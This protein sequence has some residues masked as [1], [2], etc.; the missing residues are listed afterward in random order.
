MHQRIMIT[1]ITTCVA[2][3]ALLICSIFPET[4]TFVLNVEIILLPAIYVVGNL[5]IE[6][7]LEREYRKKE[8][9]QITI[10]DS[11]YGKMKRLQEENM[12]LILENSRLKHEP[13]R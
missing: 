6:R 13:L 1:I 10:L 2:L 3:L 4:I 8:S 7:A 11:I 9:Y 5:F 12:R